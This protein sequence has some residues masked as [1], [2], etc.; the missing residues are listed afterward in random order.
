MDS[1]RRGVCSYNQEGE[2]EC[3]CDNLPLPDTEEWNETEYR[4]A[5]VRK[6]HVEIFGFLCE[7][8]M[9]PTLFNKYGVSRPSQL[10]DRMRPVGTILSR[11]QGVELSAFS[12][13]AH[14]AD[15]AQA[16]NAL[17]R[18]DSK[19][20][21]IGI[22][23]PSKVLH[24]LLPEL[25]VPWDQDIRA[26]YGVDEGLDGE[27]Y[28]AFIG[29]CREELRSVLREASV[30]ARQC[31]GSFYAGGWKP[32]TKILDELHMAREKRRPPHFSR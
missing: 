5:L 24:I 6:G 28:R 7:W 1:I 29:F 11:L 20:E 18:P 15:V 21:G 30:D 32:A 31:A 8:D 26:A 10:K 23:S 27:D 14:G 12:D 13:S 2:I 4:L 25:F 19:R 9:G 16:F 22:T 17:R 3:V